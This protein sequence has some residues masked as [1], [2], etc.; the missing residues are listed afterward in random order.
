VLPVKSLVIAQ[1]FPWPTTLGSHLRLQS[2]IR[3][4]ADLGDIDL[5]ALVPARRQEPCDVPEG[6]AIH[7]AWTVTR[8]R[9]DLSLRRRVEWIRSGLPLEVSQARVPDAPQLLRRRACSYDFVWV[10]KGATFEAVGRPRLGPT[11]VDLDDLEDWKLLSR[12]AAMRGERQ[13]AAV[14]GTAPA[15]MVAGALATVR[16]TAAIAQIR[17]NARRWRR[18]QHS[19]AAEVDRVVVCSALDRTRLGAHNATVVPN[20][21]ES[22]RVPAGRDDVGAHPTVLLPGNFCYP[23]NSDGA[24]WLVAHVLPRLRQEIPDVEVRL[25]GDPDTSVARLASIPS[26]SVVGRVPEMAPELARADIV[27]VPI[28]YGSGTRLKVLEAFANRIPVVSTT[29]G[30]EGLGAENGRELLCADEPVSF[31]R[32]CATLLRPGPTRRALVDAAQSLFREHHQTSA[33][34]T[35]VR[36]LALEVADG[37]GRSNAPG[38]PG[39]TTPE[40]AFL[41]RH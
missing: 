39:L 36:T 5:F 40:P 9:P 18:Y 3:A 20:G 31:A 27:V 11:V 12:A 14:G 23:P 13:G 29:I 6:I 41:P 10:S 30:A 15:R 24:R 22:P 4:L 32:A 26:V 7:G 37:T 33:A 21:Y 19:V 17:F 8:P 35:S 28:R 16:E 25:V 38:Q 34:R 2:V 1:D